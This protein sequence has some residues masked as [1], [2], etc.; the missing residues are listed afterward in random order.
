MVQVWVFGQSSLKAL[1]TEEIENFGNQ[2]ISYPS[3][4]KNFDLGAS[5]AMVRS[6]IDIPFPTQ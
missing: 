1:L 3:K 4:L 6:S 5:L 2:K